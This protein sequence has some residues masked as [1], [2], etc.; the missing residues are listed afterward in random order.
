M[1]FQ[2]RCYLHDIRRKDKALCECMGTTAG[3]LSLGKAIDEESNINKQIS[4]ID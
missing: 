4:N 2:E 3:N 1:G